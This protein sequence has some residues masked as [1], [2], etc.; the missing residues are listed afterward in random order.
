MHLKI[1][2]ELT[3]LKFLRFELRA[4]CLLGRHSTTSAPLPT[5]FCV[6]YF[7]DRVWWIICLGWLQIPILL[8]AA[9]W[10]IGLQAWAI[11]TWLNFKFVKSEYKFKNWSKI[12]IKI[13]W[14]QNGL[15]TWTYLLFFPPSFL[16]V[17]ETDLTMWLK[18]SSNLWSSYPSLLKL[19][20]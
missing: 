12:C 16:S 18:L 5:L 19:G 13:E 15:K 4:S 6:G 10:V 3:K 11:T 8:I 17:F 9:S 1:S 7:Q 20:L 2:W 14:V